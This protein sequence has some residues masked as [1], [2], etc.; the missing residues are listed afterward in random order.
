MKLRATLVSAAAVLIAAL[1]AWASVR[2]PVSWDWTA[3]GR[4]TLSPSSRQLLPKLDGPVS[5]TAFVAPDPKLRRT[6]A[7]LVARYQ[8]F[9]PDLTLKF[10]DPKQRPQLSRQQGIAAGGELV[11][12]YRDRKTKLRVADE[13]HLSSALMQLATQRE[14][15][16]VFASGHGER[17]PYGQ[18][19][20]D[21]KRFSDELA[22]RGMR[23]QTLNLR[24]AAVIPDNT[25]VLVLSAPQ[26]PWGPDELQALSDYL[27]RGG[28]LLWLGDP[29]EQPGLAPLAQA[30]GVRWL[31]GVVLSARSAQL[32]VENPA[33]LV[34]HL[35]PDSPL[36]V[37]GLGSVL[38]PVA[39]AMAAKSGTHWKTTPL[40]RSDAESWTET[41]SLQA[42]PLRFNPENGERR[43][44]LA[45][46]YTLSRV[47]GPR[48]QRVAVTGDGDFLSN[49][50]LANGANL[51]L[52]VALIHWL[53][54]DDLLLG[55]TTAQAADLRLE[56]SDRELALVAWVFPFVV[57]ALIAA[58]GAVVLIA[59]RRH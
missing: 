18:A 9:K 14:S 43:G 41:G 48:E 47:F 12:R 54:H 36:G 4:H 17:S 25:S 58:L 3:A 49:A 10:V 26:T 7:E 59:R 42:Q 19:N 34:A 51:D 53:D 46:G 55:V 50:Y 57:P 16:I 40:L 56:L 35:T 22:Q 1:M 52:G 20:H 23:V 31:D 2:W 15:W 39:A 5:I 45:L 29:G 13:A 28:D 33:F 24:Q 44:P 30:L 32:G 37:S 38:L 8:R 27:A 11:L 21:L 6:I